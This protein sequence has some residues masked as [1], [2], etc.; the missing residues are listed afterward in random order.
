MFAK[1]YALAFKIGMRG[2]FECSAIPIVRGF[3]LRGNFG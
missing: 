3:R 2:S 1:K